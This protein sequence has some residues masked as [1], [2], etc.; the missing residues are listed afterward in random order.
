MP[1]ETLFLTL[2]QGLRTELIVN[3]CTSLTTSALSGMV[4]GSP[5]LRRLRADGC[6]SLDGELGLSSR[7]LR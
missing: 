3:G 4:N 1:P 6:A 7:A 5:K 2:R